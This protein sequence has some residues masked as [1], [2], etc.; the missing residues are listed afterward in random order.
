METQENVVKNNNEYI[1]S[2][3]VEDSLVQVIVSI[4]EKSSRLLA[5][6]TLLLLIPKIILLI[7]HLI[8]LWFLRIAAVIAGIFGQVMV[9]FTGVYPPKVHLFVVGVIRW[10]T[11][12]IVYI[13]GLRDEYPRFTLDK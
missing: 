5:G 8:V 7:P 2:G 12:V 11:R 10:Q 13:T 6:L 1:N 3:E 4:P 9:L